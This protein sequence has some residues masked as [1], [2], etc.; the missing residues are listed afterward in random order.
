MRWL[1][2]SSFVAPAP[3]RESRDLTRYRKAQILAHLDYVDEAIAAL[4]AEIETRL[5]PFAEAVQR[6]C[7]IPGVRA[8]TAEVVVAEIGLASKY[9]QSS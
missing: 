8:R 6:L 9:R 3:I 5:A 7:T 4:T 1:V 2:R